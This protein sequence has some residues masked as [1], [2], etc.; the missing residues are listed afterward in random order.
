MYG[1]RQAAAAWEKYFAEDL[2]SVGLSTG[3]SCGVVFYHRERNISLA[4]HGDDFTCCGLDKNLRWARS[5]MESWYEIKVSAILG[6]QER[7]DK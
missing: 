1:M 7:D 2:S 5:H 6:P 4:V 3:I